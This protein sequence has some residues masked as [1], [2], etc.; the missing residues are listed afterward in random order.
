MNR[1]RLYRSTRDRKIAGVA[2]GLADYL[3]IDATVI[4]LIW[5]FSIFVG[6]GFAYILSWIVIPEEPSPVDREAGS[7]EIQPERADLPGSADQVGFGR[8]DLDKSRYFLFAQRTAALGPLPLFLAFFLDFPGCSAFDPSW[9]GTETFEVD[10]L[11]QVFDDH[12][13]WSFLRTFTGC[14]GIT[15][16]N[17]RHDC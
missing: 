10:R 3:N 15:N 5:I 17:Y 6:G 4:R 16:G 1:A 8:L 2:G 9:K 12:L 13:Q 7:P 11:I 14:S